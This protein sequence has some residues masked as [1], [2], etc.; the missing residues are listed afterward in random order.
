[1]IKNKCG[2]FE[3]TSVFSKTY[4]KIDDEKREKPK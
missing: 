2:A 1:M 3:D 4:S